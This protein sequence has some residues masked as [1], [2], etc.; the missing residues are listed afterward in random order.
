MHICIE[1]VTEQQHKDV[2]IWG[3]S[4]IAQLAKNPPAMQ[5]TWV[6]SLGWEDPLE[7]GKAT[8]SVFWPGEFHGLYSPWGHKESDT[9]EH[10]SL[11][12]IQGLVYIL[13]HMFC[14]LRGPESKETPAAK[15]TPGIKI[16]VSNACACSVVS[17][18][19]QSHELCSP[20][21]PSVHRIFQARI[22]EWAAI[23]S[24]RGSP[25]PGFPASPALAGRFFTTEL[26][27]KPSVFQ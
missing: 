4:L 5:E 3:A 15:I 9:T 6:W 18:S 26:H 19:L 7:K 24:C 14:P 11:H 23:S 1:T 10:L 25:K 20:P 22:L 21:D 8:H 16:L 17:D 13:A 27:R 2:Y 12:F